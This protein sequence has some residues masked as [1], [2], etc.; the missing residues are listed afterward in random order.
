MPIGDRARRVGR[1]TSDRADKT[2]VVEVESLKRHRIYGKQVTVRRRLMA[3]DP[4]NVCRIGDVVEIEE[5]RPMSRRKRWRLLGLLERSELSVEEKEAVYAAVAPEILG[6]MD[7]S[8]GD[9]KVVHDD[10]D[11]EET[12]ANPG[13]TLPDEVPDDDP[14]AKST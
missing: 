5:S 8:Q 2:I 3:H 10:L 6:D 14:A 12:D 11:E 4:K 7:G 13:A 1:V 9:A